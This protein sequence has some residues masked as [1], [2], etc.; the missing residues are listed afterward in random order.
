MAGDVVP[1]IDIAPSLAGGPAGM[2][3]VADEM[4]AACAGAGAFAI[5]GHGVAT[6][7]IDDLR[8]TA[9][10]FFALPLAEK[11]RAAH[12][13]EGTPRGYRA[14]AGEALGRAE[15][16][17]SAPDLKEFY[18]IGRAAWP[19]DA[20]H[21]G[22]DGRRY[23]IANLWPERPACLPSAAMAYYAA[24]EALGDRLMALAAL[25]LDLPE[26]WFEDKFDRHVTAMRINYYP[27]QPETPDEGQI[28]AGAHN[29]FGT[30]T[31]LMG[32]DGPGGLQFRMPDGAWVDVATHP[33][34][35]I[36]NIGDLFQRWTNDRW[37][38]NLHR[39]VNPPRG[40][41]A[42]RRISVGFFHQPNYDAL[43]ECLPGCAGPGNPPRYAPVRSGDYRDM[44]YR[45]TAVADE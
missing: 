18:H 13:M 15:T 33:G 28:R 6:A 38:S 2:R 7:V 30:F 29:D 25:A 43:I 8:A 14:F 44:K 9:H 22:E 37:L 45:Q 27:P 17:G 24:M 1:L 5:T 10:E 26:T 42:S 31:I 3:R 39:V 21:R 36:V 16:S 23:F 32:E 12:P 41:A 11:A 40:A 20:Y 34:I 4:A 19:D 35:F